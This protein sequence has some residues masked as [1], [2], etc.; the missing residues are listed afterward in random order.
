MKKRLLRRLLL[1]ICLLVGTC[2]AYARDG[3]VTLYSLNHLQS[4][5]LP[6]KASAKQSLPAMGGLSAAAG[7]V[8]ADM[9]KSVNPIFAATGEA[10]AGTMWRYFKGRPEMTALERAGVAVNSLGKH[11]FDYGL[12]HLKE[13]LSATRIPIVISNLVTRDPELPGTLQKNVV[14]QAG[15][16]KVGFFGLLSPAIMR[17]TNQPEGV[18]FDPDFSAVAREMVDD[19]RRKGADVIVLL[20]G[21]Y[22]NESVAL[23][24]SVAGI[25]VI[26]GCGSPVREADKPIFIKDPEGGKTVLIWS[27]VWGQFV[28]RLGIRIKDGRLDA[29]RTSWKLLPIR[30]RAAPDPGVLEVALEYEDKLARALSRVIGNFARPIDA[31]EKTLR[32]GEAPIGNFITDS[33][34]F[35]AGTDVALINSGG[36]RGDIIYPAGKFSERT[37]ADMLPFGDRIFV[38]TLTGKEL[39]RVLEIS[40][41]ALIAG[42]A[43]AYDPTKRLHKGSFLQVS[44]LKAV[45][46]L[47]EPP[48]VM[49]DDRVLTLGSRLKSLLVLKDGGWKEVADDGTY[50]VATTGW[51]A[52]GDDAEKYGI[53]RS[54]SR[55][56]T[57]YLD[58][59]AFAEYLAV[60]CRGKADP[61]KEGRIIVTG[62]GGER[63]L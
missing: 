37:L 34:R 35:K 52:N 59:D 21:L 50:T 61:R 40:A 57:P 27:G 5:L 32:T 19:L 6:V 47:S 53:L 54:A 44:G 15:D 9:R 38:L 7:I 16:M 3:E 56:E 55:T 28:G 30:D 12:G 4:R 62:R 51:M 60:G 14:L 41:S 22:E 20:S 26:T 58:T 31:R 39:R 48:T 43:D 45:Y 25:H 49:K 63:P 10:V 13:A 11:E 23:A 2:A 17:L 46:D 33:M 36:I 29:R 8:K 42:E 1:S 24:G 18:S